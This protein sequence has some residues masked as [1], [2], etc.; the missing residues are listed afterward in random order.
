MIQSGA[1][2]FSLS[3]FVCDDYALFMNK[4]EEAAMEA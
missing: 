4:R 3:L 1:F 2:W